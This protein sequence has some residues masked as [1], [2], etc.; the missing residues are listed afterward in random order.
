[1]DGSRVGEEWGLEAQAVLSHFYFFQK[2]L[3]VFF[4]KKKLARLG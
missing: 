4:Q 2:I 1:V 3:N